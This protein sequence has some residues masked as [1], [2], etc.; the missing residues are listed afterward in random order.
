MYLYLPWVIVF[1]SIALLAPKVDLGA[2]RRA[3]PP[4]LPMRT[5]RP[6]GAVVPVPE[7]RAG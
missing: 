2:R 1:T 7:E 5:A 6:S 4:A 3:T